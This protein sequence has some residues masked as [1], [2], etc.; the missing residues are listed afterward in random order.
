MKNTGIIKKFDEL[1]RVVLAKEIRKTKGWNCRDLLGV[2]VN[3]E[4]I[5]LEKIEE[6]VSN[7]EGMTRRIDELGRVVIPIEIRNTFDL[8]EGD[9][10]ELYSDK[11]LILLKKFYEGCIYCGNKKK[12]YKLLGKPICSKCI[13]KIKNEIQE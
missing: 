4:Y 13:D 8:N 6:N 12:V 9:P 2:S 10:V 11:G 1:G 5:V 3:G 7:Y